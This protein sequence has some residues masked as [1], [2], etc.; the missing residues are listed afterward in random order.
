VF[1]KPGEKRSKPPLKL[2]YDLPTI[3]ATGANIFQ[4]ES[5]IFDM[6]AHV[7]NNPDVYMSGP[8][9]AVSDVE[10]NRLEQEVYNKVDDACLEIGLDCYCPHQTK[11][12]PSNSIEHGQIWDIDYEMVVSSDVLVAYISHPALGVGAE[13]EM[14]REAHN[15][16][17]LLVEYDDWEA[18]MEDVSRLVTGNPAI[19]DLLDFQTG[20]FADIRNDLKRHLFNIFSDKNLEQAAF[21]DDWSDETAR[22]M[23]QQL[24]DTE[25]GPAA[26]IDEYKPLTVDEWIKTKQDS[27]IDEDDDGFGDGPGQSRIA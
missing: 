15:D 24:L 20:D 1:R 4:C 9:S 3:Y 11:T 6:M 19:R 25:T 16:I 21:Q 7:P 14:A 10:Q 8:L 18:D 13:I 22:E 26:G 12:T 17:I 2:R 27:D 23:R 5:S